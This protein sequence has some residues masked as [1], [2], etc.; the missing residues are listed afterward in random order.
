MTYQP[1]DNATYL[2][3][4]RTR[5]GD[6]IVDVDEGTCSCEWFNDLRN[7]SRSCAHLEFV[8]GRLAGILSAPFSM[9]GM[10]NATKSRRCRQCRKV[11]ETRRGELCPACHSRQWVKDNPLRRWFILIRARA[12]RKHREFSLSFDLFAERAVKAG[13]NPS[14]DNRCIDGLSIDRRN[15]DKGY[16]DANTRIIPYGHN[17]SNLNETHDYD[18]DTHEWVPKYSNPF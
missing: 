11:F 15:P 2:V 9:A 16:T 13:Y 4:S 17:S 6:H 3:S 5:E 18:E 12:K 14:M 7:E 10:L 8:R 1:Y